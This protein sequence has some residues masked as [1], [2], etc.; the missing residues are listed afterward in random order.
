[1]TAYTNG[2]IHKRP[3]FR[4]PTYA[5]ATMADPRPLRLHLLRSSCGHVLGI[6]LVGR[7]QRVI[8]WAVCR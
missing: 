8:Q 4:R 7:R 6:A 1:M 5:N 2:P 3:R